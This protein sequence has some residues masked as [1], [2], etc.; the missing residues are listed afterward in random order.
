MP[1]GQAAEKIVL[2]QL[3]CISADWPVAI[4]ASELVFVLV[5]IDSGKGLVPSGTKPLPE[6]KLTYGQLNIRC[7]QIHLNMEMKNDWREYI[8][9]IGHHVFLSRG[10]G[11][12]QSPLHNQFIEMAQSKQVLNWILMNELEIMELFDI[13]E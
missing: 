2:Y 12:C 1:D 7:N 13:S 10:A 4:K 8:G 6:P 11:C 5:N 3:Q 9:N